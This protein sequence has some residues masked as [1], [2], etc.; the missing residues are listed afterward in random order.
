MTP[1]TV[2]AQHL[3]VGQ[4]ISTRECPTLRHFA[5]LWPVATVAAPV[6]RTSPGY[7]AV[8]YTEFPQAGAIIYAEDQVLVA[9]PE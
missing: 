6:R 7:V 8:E 9:A 2:Q 1:T 3:Q 4:R 5:V